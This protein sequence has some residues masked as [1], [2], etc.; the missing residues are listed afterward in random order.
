MKKFVICLL[1][2]AALCTTCYA[3]TG[4]SVAAQHEVQRRGLYCEHVGGGLEGASASFAAAMA[5]PA[6]DADKWQIALYVLPTNCPP[7]EK[8]KRDFATAKELA[9]FV[10]TSDQRASACHY[11]VVQTDDVTQRWRI[12][13]VPQAPCVV[14][15]PPTSGAFGDP[16]NCLEPIVG[17]HKPAEMADLIRSRIADYVQD[18]DNAQKPIA[19]RYRAADTELASNQ[20]LPFAFPKRQANEP[21]FPS[22]DLN[23]DSFFL[24]ALKEHGNEIMTTLLTLAGLGFLIYRDYRKQ[25]GQTV[26]VPDST[27]GIVEKATKVDHATITAIVTAVLAAMNN[28]PAQ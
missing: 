25:T 6:T 19:I 4:L 9:P 13:G 5:P 21:S 20:Q 12:K 11:H 18:Y 2:C 26:Y 1:L 14:I 23:N 27:A 28:K 3:G 16:T 8:L 22:S 15:Q 17:Y 7:C 10:N 24:N